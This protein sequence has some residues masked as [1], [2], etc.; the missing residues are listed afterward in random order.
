MAITNKTSAY[1]EQY[2]EEMKKELI[3]NINSDNMYSCWNTFQY[4]AKNLGSW[5][6]DTVIG[7]VAKD[8]FI[9]LCNIIFNTMT[10]SKEMLNN[11]INFNENQKQIN[12]GNYILTE[13][14]K[15]VFSP[16]GNSDILGGIN[17]PSD[18]SKEYSNTFN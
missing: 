15:Y 6:D 8:D 13:R 11:L 1:I 14:D 18:L 10:V 7:S 9:K 12:G 16:L 5:A 3:E 17:R 4:V 2:I